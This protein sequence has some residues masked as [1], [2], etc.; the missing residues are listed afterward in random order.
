VKFAGVFSNISF[1]IAQFL[2]N[3]WLQHK[4]LDPLIG[5]FREHINKSMKGLQE[6]GFNFAFQG[7]S[8]NLKVTPLNPMTISPNSIS[9]YIDGS[10]QSANSLISTAMKITD[11]KYQTVE[12]MKKYI[13]TMKTQLETY[14]SENWVKQKLYKGL[15]GQLDESYQKTLDQILPLDGNTENLSSLDLTD[16]R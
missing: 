8:F 9:L 4:F 3:K 16:G 11:N 12:K 2:F 7:V 15:T 5:S 14:I 6:S 10:L 13:L 1:D